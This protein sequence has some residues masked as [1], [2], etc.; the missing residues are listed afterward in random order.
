VVEVDLFY[1]TGNRANAVSL[2]GWL[3][4]HVSVSEVDTHACMSFY[5][6]DV[7]TTINTGKRFKSDC[8]RSLSI[9]CG[10]RAH[11]IH[12]TSQHRDIKDETRHCTKVY[13][14]T[15]E[16]SIRASISRISYPQQVMVL[17]KRLPC[18]PHRHINAV[19]TPLHK[20]ALICASIPLKRRIRPVAVRAVRAIRLN[21]IRPHRV[22]AA[23]RSKVWMHA[24]RLSRQPSRRVILQ[25]RVK[26]V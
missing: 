18:I 9:L 21:T 15:S 26:E 3:T 1:C 4:T 13:L 11:S 24:R 2:P 5:D 7:S 8:K 6:L 12:Y 22:R 23:A 19:E 20:D 14:T 10:S 25:H 16:L 17:P